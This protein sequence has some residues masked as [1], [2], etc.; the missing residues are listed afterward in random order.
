MG[1][2]VNPAKQFQTLLGIG[3]SITDASAEVFAQLSSEKQKELLTAY[4]DPKKGNA[5]NLCRTSIHSADF[6]GKALPILKKA[7][8]PSKA[9]LLSATASTAF[10]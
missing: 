2:Y 3:G 8:N 5:Y 6:S 1:I 10:Q 9:S 7:I 4:F